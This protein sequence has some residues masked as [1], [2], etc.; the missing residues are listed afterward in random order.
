MCCPLPCCRRV[1]LVLVLIV[2]VAVSLIAVL[3]VDVSTCRRRVRRC[4]VARRCRRVN[5]APCRGAFEVKAQRMYKNENTSVLTS[6]M[7]EQ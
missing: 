5:A 4:R 7:N 2:V 6:E 1:R 3:V